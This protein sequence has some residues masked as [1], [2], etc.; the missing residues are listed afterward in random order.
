MN[1]DKTASSSN[2]HLWG[3]TNDLSPALHPQIRAH[4]ATYTCPQQLALVVEKDRGIV[5]EPDEPPVWPLDSL[6][7]AD[8]DR[9]TH[10][11]SAN[12]DVGGKAC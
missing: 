1:D 5:V 9:A 8:D 2:T 4:D 7:C 10:V 6:F 11:P 12:L 3:Q